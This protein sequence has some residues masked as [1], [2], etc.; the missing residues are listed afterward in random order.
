MG[1]AELKDRTVLVTGAGSGIGR[2]TALAFARCGAR[3]VVSDINAT[4]LTGVR[5]E[6]EALGTPCHVHIADVADEVAMR[7]MAEAVHAAVGP[8][9]V[10]VNN[11]GIGYLG[12]FVSSPLESWRRVIDINVMGVVHGCY[13]FLPRMVAAGGPRRIV[14]VAS[15]A[16]IAPAAT[17][18]AYA[19]SKHAVIGLSDV[20]AL[21]LASTEVG[22]TTVCPG[23]IDTPITD[24]PAAISP[25]VP[26]EQLARL[27]AYYRANGAQPERVADAIVDGVTR[28]RS[29]VLVGPMARPAYHIKRISRGLLRRLSLADSRKAGYL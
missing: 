8:L 11:A 6:I 9:D 24:S 12:S 10:L 1:L 3:L 26:A 7:A 16:G 22:V 27:R 29:L 13:F 28:G 5:T 2:A 18:S 20:L 17:M 19:A 23:I 14:N 21:E 15:L 4:A 25:S